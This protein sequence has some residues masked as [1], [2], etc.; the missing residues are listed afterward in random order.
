M[1]GFRSSLD[2]SWRL[3]LPA[4]WASPQ[5]YYLEKVGEEDRERGEGREKGRLIGKEKR[6]TW[7]GVKREKRFK[8][9]AQSSNNPVSEVTFKG[10]APF[11]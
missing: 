3:H 1:T 10:F 2:V 7:E 9:E 8:V 4:L 5:G 11:C 6:Q